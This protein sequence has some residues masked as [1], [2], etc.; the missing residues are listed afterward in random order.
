MFALPKRGK[1]RFVPLAPAL[2]G[3]I[4]EYLE[5]YP[6]VCV[7]LPW[8]SAEGEPVTVPLMIT[9]PNGGAIGGDLFTK[10]A[11][12]PAFPR[13]GWSIRTA[14]MACTRFGICTPQRS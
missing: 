11:W 9:H 8:G 4:D 14:L 3:D 12:R 5:L 6:P 10:I 13:R 1:T 7:T 2:L